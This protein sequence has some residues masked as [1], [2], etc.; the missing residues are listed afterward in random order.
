M[1]YAQL[2]LRGKTA[3]MLGIENRI[4][5]AAR[6]CVFNEDGKLTVNSD[7]VAVAGADAVTLLVAA[8]TN[9]KR[10]NDLG[11]DLLDTLVEHGCW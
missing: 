8:A 1:Y 2:V 3:S 7:H 5:Y 10:Y 6:V 9:F 4:R 11:Y